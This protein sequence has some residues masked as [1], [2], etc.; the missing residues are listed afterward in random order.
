MK[1]FFARVQAE[2]KKFEERTKFFTTLQSFKIPLSLPTIKKIVWA[3]AFLAFIYLLLASVISKSYAISASGGLTWGLLIFTIFV[4]LVNKI[5]PKLRLASQLLP[6][7]KESGVFAFGFGLLHAFFFIWK[8][9]GWGDIPVHLFENFSF[10]MGSISLFIMLPLFLTST[11]WA[12]R[13][14]GF[15]AWK[16]LH[17]LTH[18]IFVFAGL[19]I[20]FIEEFE[21]GPLVLL[22]V[23]FC[24]MGYVHGKKRMFDKN[25]K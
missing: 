9:D 10:T 22:F 8:I 12:I 5:L 21:G 20:A 6:L 11:S 19:H 18:V 4:S 23:Y 16:I 2:F 17:K 13:T 15:K 1:E 25:K 7:R 24:L 14:M 3:L